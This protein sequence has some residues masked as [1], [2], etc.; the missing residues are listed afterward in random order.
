MADSGPAIVLQPRNSWNFN[1]QSVS[2]SEPVRC[3]PQPCSSGLSAVPQHGRYAGLKGWHAAEG[4]CLRNHRTGRKSSRQVS[5]LCL[6][7]P[8]GAT[9]RPHGHRRDAGGLRGLCSSPPSSP[10]LPPTSPRRSHF[11]SCFF[12]LVL[13]YFPFYVVFLQ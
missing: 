6:L 1:S 10:V 4:G 11:L 3:T 5:K 13:T 9:S 12:S 7:G 2:W 8:L